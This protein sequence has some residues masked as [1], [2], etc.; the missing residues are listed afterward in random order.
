MKKGLA[1]SPPPAPGSLCV[2][3]RKWLGWHSGA[4]GEG[5][6]LLQTPAEGVKYIPRCRGY[7]CH[8]LVR[9][10]EVAAGSLSSDPLEFPGSWFRV[11]GS[12]CRAQKSP[13]SSQ[14]LERHPQGSTQCPS[15][16]GDASTEATR[17]EEGCSVPGIWSYC[18]SK[19]R[20]ECWPELGPG[21]KCG[22]SHTSRGKPCHLPSL[23]WGGQEP[24]CLGQTDPIPYLDPSSST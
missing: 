22:S 7:R 23:Q 17:K 6:S 21:T 20:Q 14:A 18:Q 9:T 3:L 8:L 12:H 1:G 5:T 13:G 10:C 19:R 4:Q 24:R 2:C 16:L 11:R 15:L